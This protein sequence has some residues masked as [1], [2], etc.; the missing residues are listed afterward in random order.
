MKIFRNIVDGFVKFVSNVNDSLGFKYC[1]GVK[2]I[3]DSLRCAKREDQ[4]SGGKLMQNIAKEKKERD[5]RII[6]L[7][8]EIE[9]R[10]RG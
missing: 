3:F 9:S 7:L 5:E 8:E 6:A 10:T 1:D 4:L 2:D